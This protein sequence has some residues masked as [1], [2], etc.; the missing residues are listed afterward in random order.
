MPVQTGGGFR[1]ASGSP[2]QFLRLLLSN[3][4]YFLDAPRPPGRAIVFGRRLP[5]PLQLL[6]PRP[7]GGKIVRGKHGILPGLIESLTALGSPSHSLF[8]NCCADRVNLTEI[9]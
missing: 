5:L 7:D 4:R 1:T 2:Q 6:H 3:L 8:L 9:K